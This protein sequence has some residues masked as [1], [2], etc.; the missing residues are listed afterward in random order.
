MESIVFFSQKGKIRNPSKMMIYKLLAEMDFRHFEATG[1]PITNLEYEAWPW[2]PVP[3]KFHKEITKD[4][5]TFLPKD[6]EEALT[7]QDTMFENEAG[8][9]FPGF[10]FIALRRPNLR[11]FSPRQQEIMEEVAEIYKNAT[12]TEAS[13]GSHELGKPWTITVAR[14]G[15]GAII[16]MID[17]IELRKPLTKEIV[18][19][20][21]RE[22]KAFAYNYGE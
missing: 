17:V 11:I 6:F 3:A 19:E 18:Q 12:A 15:K 14:K 22:K 7:I 2:G 20:M 8:K 4:K 21:M 1:L 5:N 16:D 9:R 10:K 13:L